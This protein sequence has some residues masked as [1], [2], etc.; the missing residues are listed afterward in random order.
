MFPVYFAT[1]IFCKSNLA[2]K[3]NASIE[4]FGRDCKQPVV[5]MVCT[6]DGIQSMK[7]GVGEAVSPEFA[8]GPKQK[9][10]SL[11]ELKQNM[12]V[13]P[14]KKKQWVSEGDNPTVSRVNSSNED[15]KVSSEGG[16]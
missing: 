14:L 16:R 4:N 8:W 6:T 13:P 2:L 1:S 9:K 10:H 11:E 7:Y 5:V 15:K 12:P 3:Q